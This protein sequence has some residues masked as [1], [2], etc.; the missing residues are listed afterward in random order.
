MVGANGFLARAIL[1]CW[2][3][4][5]ALLITASHSGPAN[6]AIDLAAETPP[7]IGDLPP[8]ITHA[9]ICSAVTSVDRCLRD[10][11]YAHRLNVTNT[12][13]LIDEIASQGLRPV[14]CSTDQ[15]FKGETGGYDEMDK[16]DPQTAYGRQKVAVETHLRDHHPD[17]L[18]IRMG[19]LFGPLTEDTSPIA[20]IVQAIHEGREIPAASDFYLSMTHI[21]DVAQALWV[22]ASHDAR[23]IYHLAS[24]KSLTRLDLAKAIAAAAGRADLVQ[25]ISIDDLDLLEPRP[26]NTVLD[27]SKF[28][29]EFGRSFQNWEDCLP[30]IAAAFGDV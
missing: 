17:S 16:P 12:I 25:T 8:G 26:K 4:H 15:V 5:G 28:R 11:E 22:L 3:S 13:A 29:S 10:W 19:K 23:G 14:F 1:R 18:I 24:E 7:K 6:L 27:S 9:V 2:K 20:Q 21:D 30:E